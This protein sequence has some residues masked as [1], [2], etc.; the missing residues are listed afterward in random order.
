MFNAKPTQYSTV[1]ALFAISI[2]AVAPLTSTLA[3][4]VY[5]QPHSGS[6]TLYQSS[7]WD[8]DDSDYDIHIWDNFTLPSNHAI[9][10]VNWRGGFIYGGAWGGPVV[11][12][13]VA[14]Y[15]SIAANS[16]PDVVGGPLVQYDTPGNAGQ[17]YA[18]TFGGVAMYD[19]HFTLPAPFQAA[20]NTK[21]WVYI[22]A[23]QH[24]IP[25]WAFAQGTG[26]NGGYFRWVRGAHMYQ[27]PPGDMAFTLISSDAS[28][29][30]ISASASPTNAGTVQ[31]AGQYP[32]DST[33]SLLA[34]P[35]NGWGFVNWTEN[36]T[37][38][39]VANPYN[40][41]VTADRTLVA[42]FIPAYTVTTAAS[43]TYGGTTTG[44][45]TYDAGTLVTVVATANANFTFV[46]WTE[47]GNPVSTS[48]TYQFNIA[49]NRTL[50]ANFALNSQSRIFDFDNAPVHT[51]LPID[52]TIGGL[53]AHFSATGSGFSIQYA[54]AMGFT[55]AGFAGLCIYPNSV[56]PADLI[57]DFDQPLADFSIM[58]SPQELGCDDSATMRA[59]G[60]MN[61]VFVATNTVTAPTHG[62][63]PT[64]TL[65]LTAP[66]GF[67][68][69]VVHY[70]AKPPTCQDWGPIFLADNMIVT[71]ADV[72]APG[73]LNCDGS[74]NGFDV[75]PFVLALTDPTGYAGQYPNCD[76]A[77]GDINADG[78]V[79]G[80]DVDGF[81]ALLGGG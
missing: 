58:Y 40:F 78:S 15:P 49:A 21:Y 35:N 19:Y 30:T 47:F 29:F 80:F 67:N 7:W 26:G 23:A 39:S 8:P 48:P 14:I 79:N 13:T 43:P 4:V 66:A 55:P 76:I 24:G 10:E 74:V 37:P 44:D 46:N 61:G 63:W 12:F 36:G 42:N 57:V 27:A 60:Y 51:S 59:T 50:V 52:L 5:S 75:D 81:V 69:V 9:T 54:N 45:G 20:A 70:D 72:I 56:F 11:Y 34:I 68:R 64:G 62:T 22:V 17:T 53:T 73:D 1:R 25:E 16:E 71:L 33:A 32:V 38:V 28:T 31:G 41:V 6:G 3:G 65:T 2:A 77:A 18:G